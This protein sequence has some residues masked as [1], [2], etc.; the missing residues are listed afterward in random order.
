[1]PFQAFFLLYALIL[2]KFHYILTLTNFTGVGNIFSLDKRAIKRLLLIAGSIAGVS[3]LLSV[4]IT[5]VLLARAPDSRGDFEFHAALPFHEE[6]YSNDNEYYYFEEIDMT[7]INRPLSG[8]ED[9]GGFL[10]D[11]FFKSINR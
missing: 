8:E 10:R 1:L 4:T 5:V 9:E 6:I 7:A 11:K 2:P 3:L